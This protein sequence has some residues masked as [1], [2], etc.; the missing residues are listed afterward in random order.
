M[1]RYDHLIEFCNKQMKLVIQVDKSNSLTTHGPIIGLDN[2][3][4]SI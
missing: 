3:Y 4:D 1:A 2:Q